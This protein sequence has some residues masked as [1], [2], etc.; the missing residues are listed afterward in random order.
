M[1][2][3]RISESKARVRPV[4]R[5]KQRLTDYHS[6][7]N[8]TLIT[9]ITSKNTLPKRTDCSFQKVSEVGTDE[10]QGHIYSD[11]SSVKLIQMVQE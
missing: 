8:T 6:K 10:G 11:Q 7:G 3:F 2:T 9:T 5:A 1:P 4:I